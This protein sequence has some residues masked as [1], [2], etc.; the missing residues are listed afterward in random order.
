MNTVEA[1]RAPSAADPKVQANARPG[2]LSMTSLQYLRGVAAMMV[3]YFH[4]VLQLQNLDILTP[5]LPLIGESGVDLFFVLSGF[6]MW[7]TTSRSS[8][9]PLVFMRR[10]LIRIVPL[11]WALTLAAGAVALL[12]P[13]LLKSTVLQAWHF[14]SS[15][16]FVPAANPAFPNGAPANLRF[17]PVLIPGWTL[18]YEMFFYLIFALFI[19][20]RPIL[21][22]LLVP[23]A[24][25]LLW[26]AGT[27]DM[28]GDGAMSFY[29]N[30]IIFQF[31]LGMGVAVLVQRGWLLTSG[32][33]SLVALIAAVA[34]ITADLNHSSLRALTF[35][36]PA[37]LIVYCLCSLEVNDRPRNLPLLK[38]LGD[39]SYS[40]YLT[41]VFTLAACRVV[42]L[43]L[44]IQGALAELAFIG[45]AMCVSAVVGVLT[46]RLYEKPAMH[47]LER[48]K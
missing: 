44:N 47:L 48:F 4:A 2:Q 10:R 3:V 35:G 39:A 12:A 38:V 21:R 33:A 34:L 26:L 23:L 28:L 11:Y 42:F 25:A 31:V 29:G 15:M 5:G 9:T 14:A 43:R 37:A 46:Y 7:L 40:V 32:W 24:F 20:V 41:H 45:T 8:I 17:T 27:N 1:L 30:P 13:Q 6:L 19:V 22:L 36:V 18:N 16:L